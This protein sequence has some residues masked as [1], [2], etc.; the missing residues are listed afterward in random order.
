MASETITLADKTTSVFSFDD[1]GPMVSVNATV[2]LDDEGLIGGIAGGPGDVAG[3][4]I[5]FSG[6]LGH[7]FGTDGA[8]SIDFASMTTGTV[9][10]ESVNY[11]WDAATNTLLAEVS[12]GPRV[13]TDLFKVVVNPATGAYTV[14]QLDNVLHTPPVDPIVINTSNYAAQSGIVTVSVAVPGDPAAS[15]S[16][17]MPSASSRRLTAS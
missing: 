5:T 7:S 17:A 6:T 15:S 11:S 14:T 2:Q 9:G 3:E 12:S 16:T 13:G 4:A 10:T 8:G 1:D